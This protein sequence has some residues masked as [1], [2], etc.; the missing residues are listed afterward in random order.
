MVQYQEIPLA[1]RAEYLL[2][3]ADRAQH[4]HE[5]VIPAL[6]N[7]ALVISDR[8]SD[9]SLAYQGFG[10]G[11]DLTMIKII[12]QWTMQ[13]IEPDLTIYLKIPVSIAYARI[14]T[15][16]AW[17][18][19]IYSFSYVSTT[20]RPGRARVLQRADG[21][22]LDR[23][24]QRRLPRSTT[25]S[26]S[27]RKAPSRTG[28][29]TS[30]PPPSFDVTGSDYDGFFG[31]GALVIAN[32]SVQ[33]YDDSDNSTQRSVFGAKLLTTQDDG[34]Q[35]FGSEST[36]VSLR[37]VGSWGTAT[38]ACYADKTTHHIWTRPGPPRSSRSSCRLTRSAQGR[39][40]DGQGPPRGRA[41]V[42]STGYWTRRSTRARPRPAQGRRLDGHA[43]RERTRSGSS[44]WRRPAAPR[45]DLDAVVVELAG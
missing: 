3:A 32:W 22:L 25:T 26:G 39:A 43:A 30:S 24:R 12:N 5:V 17:F 34:S 40:G 45:V 2:F 21:F 15:D 33:A 7:D 42:R 11:H 14:N 6:Q 8:M 31:G 36:D 37:Y 23:D 10:R 35:T 16:N 38:C 44:T 13:G 28:S 18:C 27:T 20:R 9:S 4:F 1:P 19:R 41:Q 29:A